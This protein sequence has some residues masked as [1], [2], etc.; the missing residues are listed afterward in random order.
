MRE[1][2]RLIQGGIIITSQ[3]EQGTAIEIKAPLDEVARSP[4]VE[5]EESII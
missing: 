4:D 2:V 3:P 1:R 5:S